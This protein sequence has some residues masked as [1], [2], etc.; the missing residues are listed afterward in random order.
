MRVVQDLPVKRH[1]VL[2]FARS[3]EKVIG[4]S[5]VP[6]IHGP[7]AGQFQVVDKHIVDFYIAQ[8]LEQVNVC[9]NGFA[10]H[11]GEIAGVERIFARAVAPAAG[12]ID[13]RANVHVAYRGVGE[14]KEVGYGGVDVLRHVA[15]AEQADNSTGEE[16]E[17]CRK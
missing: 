11:R 15:D 3:A 4:R 8:S 6:P 10:V 16:R 5:R 17:E 12:E 9:K 13:S 14:G 7:L 2:D 1:R